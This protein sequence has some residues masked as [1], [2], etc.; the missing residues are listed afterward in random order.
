MEPGSS[1]DE[2]ERGWRQAYATE[3]AGRASF[4][5]ITTLD[6]NEVMAKTLVN[7]EMG[8]FGPYEVDYRLSKETTDLLLSHARQDAAWAAMNTVDIWKQLRTT[9]RLVMFCSF[10]LGAQLVLVGWIVWAFAT[11]HLRW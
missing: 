10:V 7:E 6:K 11:G 2:R 8:R 5:R 3:I 4:K 1:F 9:R